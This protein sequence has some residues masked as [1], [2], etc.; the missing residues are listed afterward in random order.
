M[1][2]LKS[3]GL[4][5]SAANLFFSG[6]S[7]ITELQ[8]VDSSLSSKSDPEICSE[9][10]GEMI[11]HF[12]DVGQGDSAFVELPNGETMLIDAG[13]SD[14]G[15]D[16]VTYIQQQ[17]YDTINYV[18]GTHPH[19]DHIGGMYDVI[20]FFNIGEVYLSPAESDTMTYSRL[21]DK[22]DENEI[23][24]IKGSAGTC[25]VSDETFSVDIIAPESDFDYGDNLNN[26]SIVIK[27]VNG[28]NT[29]VIMADAEKEESSEIE[30][31][32]CDV[33]R[34]GHHG[35]GN[36]T[37]P[38]I[39]DAATPEYAV[40]SCGLNNEYG[41][42]HQNVLD[43]LTERNINV[44]RTD[45]QGNIV[46]KSNGE[47]ISVSNAPAEINIT[48][49]SEQKS[50]AYVLNTNSMKIHKSDCPAVET[51]REY[52]RKETDDYAAA[53]NDG[54]TPCGICKP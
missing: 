45:E 11:V 51:I 36:A 35:S 37:T 4:C 22:L 42:P 14:K 18:V 54:Y 53:V 12:L 30:D 32:D 47:K 15:Q 34:L 27:I 23:A 24:Q 40:I 33:L 19:S 48:E 29:F 3:I 20:D 43:M 52:N 7:A 5:F 9:D 26:A 31:L 8:G 44:F 2:K 10:C 25:I 13:E 39:L 46:M 50:S 38:G 16:V 28:K 6:C 21:L 1:C 49:S 41:H 17:G